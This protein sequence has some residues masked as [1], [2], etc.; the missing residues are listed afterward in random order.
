MFLRGQE[1]KINTFGLNVHKQHSNEIA[2]GCYVG[3]K[4]YKT[5]F[6]MGG[7][8]PSLQAGLE[9]GS[10]NS[11]I[12]HMVDVCLFVCFMHVFFPCTYRRAG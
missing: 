11:S 2:F 9:I 10:F 6:K 8:R 1:L 7:A 12:L 5:M 4:S 3:W